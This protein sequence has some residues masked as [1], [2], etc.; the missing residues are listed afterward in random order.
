M[1]P[2]GTPADTVTRLQNALRDA[3][4]TPEAQATLGKLGYRVVAGSAQEMRDAIDRYKDAADHLLIILT[5]KLGW[6]DGKAKTKLLQVFEAAGPADP[7]RS[8]RSAPSGLR[9]R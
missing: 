3:L 5:A 9:G 1:S 4:R 6:E 2:S 7:P 8:L